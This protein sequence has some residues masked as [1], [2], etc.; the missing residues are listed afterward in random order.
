M[1]GLLTGGGASTDAVQLLTVGGVP[2]SLTLVA[3][4]R[5]TLLCVRAGPASRRDWY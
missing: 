1:Q 3:T 5:V 2:A 4:Q